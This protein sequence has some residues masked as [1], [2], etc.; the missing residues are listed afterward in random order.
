MSDIDQILAGGSSAGSRYDFSTV[1]D[2]VKGFFDAS[3]QRAAF[4]VRRAFKDGVPTLPDGSIDYG[5]M[6]RVLY[7]KGALDQ[8][9]AL[10]GIS[11]RPAELRLLVGDN[12][13]SPAPSANIGPPSASRGAS[14]TSTPSASRASTNA[15]QA[16]QGDAPVTLMTALSAQGIP[17]HQLQP[18][19]E[20]IARQL[21][22]DPTAP[23][24]LQDPQ[25]RNVVVP[26]IA[27]L[28]RM[29]V[30]QVAQAGQ[31]AN[32]PIPAQRVEMTPQ[33]DQE[34]RRLRFL[35]AS[36]DKNIAATGK[37]LLESH[38]KNKELTPDQKNAA[39]S[40]VSLTDYQNR[41]DENTTQRDILTKSILP[42]VDKSQETATAARDDVDAIYRARAELDKPGG[43]INGAFADKRLFLSKAANLL[44]VPNADKINN[45]EAYTAAIGQRVAAMV[46]AFGSGT[47]ISDGDRRFAAAMAGGNIDLDEKSMRRILD[48]GEKAARGK[49]D[50]HNALV[51]KVV[52]SNDGLKSAR[53]TYIVQA[54]DAY[55]K[56]EALPTLE[57]GKTKVN[58]L[59][60]KGG[61]P[62]D[63]ANWVR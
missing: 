1:G 19:A 23:I 39:A 41:A 62:K 55:K 30:G 20:S 3:N 51:D 53:D 33:N 37:A 35:A 18:A 34:E 61:N 29:G 12:G 5:T 25:I 26:A 44:G 54:P 45:T 50:Y 40:G 6:Q 7:Q 58:G 57:P 13:G 17:N 14:V 59:T 47:A 56:P 43:I 32:Q 27:Q 11:D 22:V 46:K 63:R 48:I 4:D 8:G 10:S 38:L 2:P 60:Y 16:P 21:G 24:N 28:K 15:P 42:R 36:R 31:P 9:N 52:K 49:I